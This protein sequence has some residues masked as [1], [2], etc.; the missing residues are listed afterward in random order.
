MLAKFGEPLVLRHEA[1]TSH[2]LT[3]ATPANAHF[4]Q[5][6]C[7]KRSVMA[8]AVMPALRPKARCLSCRAQAGG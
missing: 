2:G 8:P 3:T 7:A 1:R 5:L 6:R 4:I